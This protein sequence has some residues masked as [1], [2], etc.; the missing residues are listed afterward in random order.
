MT[1]ALHHPLSAEAG[2]NQF[3]GRSPDS[4]VNA[5]SAAFPSHPRDSGVFAVSSLLTVA[6]PRGNLTRFPFHLPFMASTLE[7]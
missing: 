5:S 3:R 1:C 7:H 4:Q 6:G 2:R